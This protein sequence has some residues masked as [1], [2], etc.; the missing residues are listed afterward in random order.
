MSIGEKLV[1]KN[2]VDF[3]KVGWKFHR[4]DFILMSIGL[5]CVGFMIYWTLKDREISHN[6]CSSI[7]RS[8]YEILQVEGK[9]YAVCGSSVIGK[10]PILKEVNEKK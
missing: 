2:I 6:L 7:N 8:G 1:M 9:Y 4:F 3:L 10:P 5:I